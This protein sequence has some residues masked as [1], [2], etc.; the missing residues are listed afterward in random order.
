[1]KA[2][3][4]K[5]DTSYQIEFTFSPY[6]LDALKKF[7]V[8]FEIFWSYDSFERDLTTVI[9][10]CLKIKLPKKRKKS[11]I[12]DKNQLQ[13]TSAKISNTRKSKKQRLLKRLEKE[14]LK[15]D[16]GKCT[17]LNNWFI[18]SL[19][20]LLLLVITKRFFLYLT[21]KFTYNSLI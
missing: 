17:L 5:M 18:K 10:T 4:E 14:I 11:V 2:V 13:P 8:N 16:G 3:I 1:M 21:L 20:L 12:A 15:R 9:K 7:N 19:A 6:I